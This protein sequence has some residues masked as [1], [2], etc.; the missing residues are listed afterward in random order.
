MSSQ[1]TTQSYG[2]S[3]FRRSRSR[4]R[5]SRSH[6]RS[7]SP[8]P[9]RWTIQRTARQ[10]I[11]R[12]PIVTKNTVHSFTRMTSSNQR[13]NL[14]P[15]AT[16]A[17]WGLCNDSLGGFCYTTNNNPI[18]VTGPYLNIWFTFLAA[19][20]DSYSNAGAQTHHIEYGVPSVGEFAALYQEFELTGLK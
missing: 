4:N 15:S 5:R 3:S 17:Y 9:M 12:S 11:R 19:H 6:S 20:F 16:P 8:S 13:N 2:S 10:R 18:I 1:S 14:D 7:P